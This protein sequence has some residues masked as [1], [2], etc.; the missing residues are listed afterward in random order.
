[1]KFLKR[2]QLSV[3]RAKIRKNCWKK[4]N[5]YTKKRGQWKNVTWQ[6]MPSYI[7]ALQLSLKILNQ[8]LKL[9]CTGGKKATSHSKLS[10]ICS[11][12]FS[13][14]IALWFVLL[15]FKYH[16]CEFHFDLNTWQ[17]L[18]SG[19]GFIIPFH[20]STSCHMERFDLIC[21]SCFKQWLTGYS[22]IILWWKTCNPDVYLNHMSRWC[23]LLSFVHVLNW[24]VTFLY[25]LIMNTLLT[26]CKYKY[27]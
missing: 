16:G 11:I 22:Y 18:N 6:Q 10:V 14:L 3:G 13:F 5:I 24:C 12:P 4:K 21:C 23:A 27:R 25:S 8:V 26:V 1:M 7:L 9:G 19:Q 17:R 15:L 20:L 2:N